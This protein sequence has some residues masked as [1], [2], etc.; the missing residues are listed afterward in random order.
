MF[1]V[2]QFKPADCAYA[3]FLVLP[4]ATWSEVT[5]HIIPSSVFYGLWI[6]CC[7][8]YAE[9]LIH[10]SASHSHRNLATLAALLLMAF[11]I[12]MIMSERLPANI[13]DSLPSTPDTVWLADRVIA[14]GTLPSQAYPNA[15]YLS[16][17][18]SIVQLSEFELAVGATSSMVPKLL[19]VALI[20]VPP[21][22]F[23]GCLNDKRIGL[24]A[25][26]VGGLSPWIL[27]PG[28]HYSPEAEGA[29]LFAIATSVL[30]ANLIQSDNRFNLGLFVM[31]AALALTDVFY[32]FIWI[33][34]VLGLTVTIALLRQ[35]ASKG[36]T[37]M[38]AF[39]T[40]A[41]SWGSWYLIGTDAS[42]VTEPFSQAARLFLAQISVNTTYL[43][44]AESVPLLIRV[45]EYVAY[46]SM[47]ACAIL[48]ILVYL[49]KV[50]VVSAAALATG[51]VAAAVFLPWVAGYHSGTDLAQRSYYVF[52]V[53][54]AIPIAYI[55]TSG[56]RSHRNLA[57]LGVI[58]V[59][60]TVPLNALAYGGRPYQYD[61][62]F[63]YSN[64]DTRFNLQSWDSLGSTVCSF[65]DAPAVW[66]VRLGAAFVTCTAYIT[67]S[68][69]AAK[70]DGVITANQLTDLN[71]VPGPGKIV[72]LR[73]S[74]QSVN[75]WAQPLP[76]PPNEI[77]SAYDVVYDSG[78]PLLIYTL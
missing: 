72:A 64:A 42:V 19:Q 62:T 5:D 58:L 66:G 77:I 73:F 15:Q 12:A 1:R 69:D 45:S 23:Y 30:I 78:D 11:S 4:F 75:E 60:V 55:L 21:I 7:V 67:L 35:W 13:L 57:V 24:I 49:K 14:Y 76:V 3:L 37:L 26:T 22:V 10:A 32:G 33:V 38:L 61:A 68:P 34:L 70:P 71:S 39:L 28:T 74:L 41:L 63:P 53:G 9:R 25:A 40:S 48:A 31:G 18:L 6:F 52:Q 43:V 65:S 16:Y 46:L 29:V 36:K 47:G 8:V 2:A 17:P 50:P 51:F 54:T 56:S 20:L 59:L 27:N 44:S